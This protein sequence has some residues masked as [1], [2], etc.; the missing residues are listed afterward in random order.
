M[1]FSTLA[2]L[3]QLTLGIKDI[4]NIKD[5]SSKAIRSFERHKASLAIR[6]VSVLLFF[7][8]AI[9]PQTAI[10]PVFADGGNT[11]EYQLKAAYLLNLS[12]FIQW[13]AE[14][15]QQQQIPFTFCMIGIEPYAHEIDAELNN[16]IVHG[17]NTR[18][19]HLGFSDPLD[20]CQVLFIGPIGDTRLSHVLKVAITKT[21]LIVGED[22]KFIARGGDISF[23]V[24]PKRLRF[25][26]NPLSL[27]HKN[28]KV[29]SKLLRLAHIVET[30][31]KTEVE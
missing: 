1:L 6:L 13:P 7:I 8:S 19:E 25:E 11:S 20:H 4:R 15:D 22:S 31:V 24:E 26:I 30:P 29:S 23:F 2:N 18:S 21:L 9:L 14:S 12:K 10:T 17:R 27:K 3:R 5:I 16:K 28:L